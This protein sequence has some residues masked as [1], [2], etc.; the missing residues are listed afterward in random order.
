M[1]DNIGLH[2]STFM[3]LNF[4]LGKYDVFTPTSDMVFIPQ[5]TWS[6]Q[7][8]ATAQISQQYIKS[9]MFSNMG[10]HVMDLAGLI[11]SHTVPILCSRF[12]S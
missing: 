8:S 11:I 3:Q 7:R 5:D 1:P 10:V 2:R 4:G 12:T 6:T 9:F